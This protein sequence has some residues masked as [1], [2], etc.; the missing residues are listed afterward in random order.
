MCALVETAHMCFRVRAGIVSCTSHRLVVKYVPKEWPL[1]EGWTER[2]PEDRETGA[3]RRYRDHS[4]P[5]L[6]VR[7]H[8]GNMWWLQFAF[9][10]PHARGW[11][12]FITL[13]R[14]FVLHAAL[15]LVFREWNGPHVH[16]KCTHA[17]TREGNGWRS[18][19]VCVFKQ[20]GRM[21]LHQSQ[22]RTLGSR[23]GSSQ[24]KRPVMRPIWAG[25][26]G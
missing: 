16:I 12:A 15:P 8:C 18:A 20:T 19:R 23:R 25:P 6:R 22:R 9:A 10:A 7:S 2:F 17:K 4:N 11:G 1:L 5:H 13:W 3:A 26:S 24:L 21:R 14:R